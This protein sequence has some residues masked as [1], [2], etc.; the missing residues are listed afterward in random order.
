MAIT[1]KSTMMTPVRQPTFLLG[2]RSVSRSISLPVSLSFLLLSLLF[3]SSASSQTL[4]GTVTDS[5]TGS[6]IRNATVTLKVLG[7]ATLTDAQGKFTISTAD[8]RSRD[9]SVMEM[10][11]I[12]SINGSKIQFFISERNVPVFIALYNVAG[13]RIGVLSNGIYNSGI[14]NTALPRKFMGT[15][16]FILQCRI[17]LRER[18]YTFTLNAITRKDNYSEFLHEE[19]STS[20]SVAT[21]SDTLLV[22]RYGYF[23]NY[24]NLSSYSGNLAIKLRP[25]P[26]GAVVPPGMKPIPAD[27]FTMGSQKFEA[28]E[29][30]EH[31]VSLSP[32]FIDSTEE[33]QADYELLLNV[34]PWENKNVQYPGSK[35]KNQPVWGVNWYDA[36]IYCNA[37][38]KRDGLDTAYSYTS[39]SGM[40]GDGC[41]L[42]NTQINYSVTGYRLPSEAEWEY[43]C[44]GGK[45]TTYYWGNI[46][47][48]APFYAW[49]TDNSQLTTH[50]VAQKRPNAFGL[51]DISGNVAEWV[52]DWYADNYNAIIAN[53][54]TG[55]ISG[56]EKV[57]RGGHYGDRND[58]LR[59]TR[60][61]HVSPVTRYGVNGFR[62]ALPKR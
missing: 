36:V 25:M 62:V 51:Y 2:R 38:S 39:L 34:K 35:G 28:N 24:R 31:E 29:T 45:R 49:F 19:M 15:G 60:R 56:I 42:T 3:L 30:P 10:S 26:A 8:V 27:T 52:N 16:V 5:I 61:Y 40:P 1:M 4:T 53:N 14:Y 22:N 32:Y 48:S 11:L 9:G 46:V 12:V 37:R 21:I 50:N 47:D 43:A 17:G 44:G 41:A 59:V 13:Q 57:Y 23:S 6:P 58:L 54:P 18:N 7:K 55:P 33:T 20:K